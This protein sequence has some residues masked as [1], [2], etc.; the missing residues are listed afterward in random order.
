M[1]NNQVIANEL[2][3][4]VTAMQLGQINYETKEDH[5]SSSYSKIEAR[6]LSQRNARQ[7][8][9][10]SKERKITEQHLQNRN[11]QASRMAAGSGGRRG[12]AIWRRRSH[13]YS[14]T[15]QRMAM[16]WGGAAPGGQPSW[17]PTA[18]P[19]ARLLVRGRPSVRV[20]VLKLKR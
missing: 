20:R 3:N 1:S 16:D 5:R 12:R 6:K 13:G 17:Q 9:A 14:Q 10:R 4:Q 11:L 2:I 18:P 15:S 8:T 19:G 7:K